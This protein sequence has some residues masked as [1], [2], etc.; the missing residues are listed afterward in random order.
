MDFKRVWIGYFPNDGIPVDSEET[1]KNDQEVLDLLND[2][3]EIVSTVPITAS[4]EFFIDGK[5]IALTYTSGVDVFMI[6]K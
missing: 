3:W 5:F 2:G 6:K 4:R 1:E